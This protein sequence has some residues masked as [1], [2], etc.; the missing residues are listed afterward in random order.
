MNPITRRGFLGVIGVGAAATTLGACAGTGSDSGGNGSGG[1]G[2]EGG[3]GTITFWSNHPGDSKDL[4]TEIIE[5]FQSENPDLTVNLVDAGKNYEEVAQKFNAALTGGDLPDVVVVSDVTWFNFALNDQL[6]PLGDLFD[7]A[8]VDTDDYV[9]A[10]LGDYV[11]EENNYGVP[12]A[13]STPLFYYNKDVW[14]KAG[15]PDRGPE[16][17]DE[18]AEWAPRLKDAIGGGKHAIAMYDGS[19]Y[20][21]W[22][23]QNIIWDHDGAFSRDWEPTFTEDAT[24]R[25]M[26]YVKKLNDDGFLVVSAD[27]IVEFGSGL[28]ACALASTGSLATAKANA[29]FE[30]GTAF[31]PGAAEKDSCPTGG[32]GVAIPAGI[33]DERKLNAMKFINFLTNTQSTAKFAQGTGYMP[34][35]K[36]AREA[37]EIKD[38]LKETPQAVTAI[39]QLEHTRPQDNARVLVPNGGRRIGGAFDSILGGADVRQT[40]QRVQ[41]ETAD[42]IER[43]IKPKL[44]N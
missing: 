38:Y 43:Q 39:E 28:A 18:F 21:D 42:I 7:E 8:G 14:S 9:D 30:F 26:E 41:D 35:R 32:A 15:L 36:S 17:W 6:A 20:M 19:N 2:G 3:G 27:S 22:T 24:I 40:M 5:A 11:L 12:F 23:G 31:L 44:G 10:L 34:V 4:E 33:S 1:S 25:G 13:R 29:N 16:N 37:Q